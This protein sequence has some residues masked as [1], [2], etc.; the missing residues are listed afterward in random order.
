M[1]SISAV[2]DIAEVLTF[3]TYLRCTCSWGRGQ[4]QWKPRSDVGKLEFG[5]AAVLETETPPK[6][7]YFFQDE[8]TGSWEATH[9]VK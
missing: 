6:F 8:A 2:S 1:I 9:R 5:E 3:D 7:V 4:R